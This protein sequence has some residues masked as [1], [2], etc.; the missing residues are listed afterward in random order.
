[1]ALN[2]S[3]EFKDVPV[4]CVAEIQFESAWALTFMNSGTRTARISYFKLGMKP[5]LV[6]LNLVCSNSGPRIQYG[7]SSGCPGFQP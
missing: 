2:R 5:C 7:S 1:M 4:V 3:P 6:V